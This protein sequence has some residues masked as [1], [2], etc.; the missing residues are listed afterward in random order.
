MFDNIDSLKS[1]GFKGF[2]PIK[3]LMENCAPIE[4]ERGIYL[5]LY[6]GEIRPEFMFKGTGGFHKGRDPNVDISIL[7]SEWVEKTIVIYIGQAGGIRCGRWSDN[8]LKSRVRSYMRFGVGKPVGHYG[9]RYIWQIKNS[10][11]LLVCWKP[12][13][14]KIRDPMEAEHEM[15]KSFHEMYGKIP[16]A[17]LKE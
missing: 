1:E 16:F 6:L 8:T 17:N 7:E 14:G 5:V 15:I 12:L 9:G 11:S 4:D 3:N 2:I 10:G 13:T